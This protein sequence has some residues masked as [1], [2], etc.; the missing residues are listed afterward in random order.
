M[1]P[2]A[3]FTCPMDYGA[4]P[5][6]DAITHGLDNRLR[7]DGTELEV[8]FA[9]FRHGDAAAAS[10]RAID[11]AV[12]EGF[13]AIVI[14]VLDPLRDREPVA[15]ARSAGVPVFAFERPRFAVDG[16]LV[17]PNFNQGVYMA[18]HLASLLAAGSRVAVIGGPKIIDDE[19]L[20][21][22]IVYGV[23]HGGL[24]RVNDPFEDRW[25]NETD[26]REGGREVARRLLSE[27]DR[28]DGLIP[29]N[30]ETM[31]GT[32]DALEETGRIGLPMVSRNGTPLAVEAVRKGSTA[33]TWD[34]SCPEI[35][36]ALGA[37]V[38]RRLGAGT[39]PADELVVGPI[40]RMIDASNLDDWKPWSERIPF[41]RLTVRDR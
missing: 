21:T 26:V 12:A 9:D 20:L 2:R 38:S 18:D 34:I 6:V 31:I 41:H 29:F 4:N 10:A 8:A 30:D 24:V 14:Y 16:A 19:E 28:L 36:A 3:L 27:Y 15:R 23:D 5:G 25:R 13:A 35:G 39:S 32:V 33:G 37:L 40:G 7:E 11:A 17:Y 1:S 22:G